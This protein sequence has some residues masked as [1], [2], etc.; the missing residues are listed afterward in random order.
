MVLCS[1]GQVGAVPITPS[2]V[3]NNWTSAVSPEV[4]GLT[5]TF[6]V[7][8]SEVTFPDRGS[9]I[10]DFTLSGNASFSG[11]FRITEPIDDDQ[12]GFYFGFQDMNSHYR[13]GWD[14]FDS[15]YGQPSPLG[16]NGVP[17]FSGDPPDRIG[18]HGLRLLK[19]VGGT[20]TY[21]Y[22]DPGPNGARPW[23][24]NTFY[25]F[26]ISRTGDT[27]SLRIDQ[28]GGPNMLNFSTIDATFTSGNVGLFTES[29]QNV[30]FSNLD[31]QG[32]QPI[33]EP[34]TMV[35]LG[36]SLVGVIGYS[37]WRRKWG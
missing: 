18:V 37:W 32:S 25:D 30:F 22:Q 3:V 2:E 26:E 4:G 29:Q 16:T 6:S 13:F 27:I 7:V 35:L 33:P 21:L 23:Q 1:V 8:G 15:N 31:A 36:T 28:V 9:K 24:R 34:S 11:R 12:T 17:N 20:V 19:E 10:S 14:A 5:G